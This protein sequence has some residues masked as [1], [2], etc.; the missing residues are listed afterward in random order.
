MS[1]MTS[2]RR[3]L[4]PAV[5]NVIITI[6]FKIG[7]FKNHK[8]KKIDGLKSVINGTLILKIFAK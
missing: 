6:K 7:I 4:C 2:D 5:N 8:L 1:E 3:G